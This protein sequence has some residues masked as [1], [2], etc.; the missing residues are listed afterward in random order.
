MS[1]VELTPTQSIVF[2]ALKAHKVISALELTY[3]VN[4]ELP[5]IQEALDFILNHR[6]CYLSSD[7]GFPKR[8]KIR[9]EKPASAEEEGSADPWKGGRGTVETDLDMLLF[10]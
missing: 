8:Y 2:G 10:S 5:E 3:R 4:L 9:E 7:G 6:L 1:F